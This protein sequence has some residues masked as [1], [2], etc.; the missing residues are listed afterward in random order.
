MPYCAAF[1]CNSDSRNEK[2]IS[3]FSFPKDTT[4][5]KSWVHYC[6][7]KHF[8]PSKHSKIC[9]KHFSMAQYSRHPATMMTLGYPGARAALKDDAVPDIHVQKSTNDSDCLTQKTPRRAFEKRRKQ[10]VS[11]FN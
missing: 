1:G 10:E 3:W 6:K 11:L 5:C 7:R 4:R 9:S 8:K 2:D